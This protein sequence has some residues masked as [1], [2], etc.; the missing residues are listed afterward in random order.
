MRNV[1][2]EDVVR[3]ASVEK[4][5]CLRD[6]VVFLGSARVWV[7]RRLRGAWCVCVWLGGDESVERLSSGHV[8][9]RKEISTGGNSVCC[10]CINTSCT[11]GDVV[12][13]VEAWSGAV[14]RHKVGRVA[15][16]V[17]LES[18][19]CGVESGVYVLEQESGLGATRGM[20]SGVV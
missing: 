7:W 3:A 13:G 19:P 15:R 18:G 4:V 14:E 5:W 12:S 10:L 16:V 8:R 11:G 6:V 20:E 2:S 1:V 9:E 17:E